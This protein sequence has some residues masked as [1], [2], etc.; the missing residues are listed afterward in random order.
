MA[1]LG[2]L[3][4][5]I[6][7]PK[8][9]KKGGVASTGTHNPSQAQQVLTLPVYREHLDDIFD[10]RQVNDSRQLMQQLFRFDPDVSATV[11]S[12]LTLANTEPLIVA[13]TLDGEID[14]EATAAAWNVIERITRVYDYTL[15]FQLKGSFEILCEQLRYMALLRGAATAELV[16][17]KTLA[18]DNVRIIDG[19]SLKWYEKKP[20]EYKPVQVQS[21]SSTEISLDI[22]TFF[23]SFFRRDPTSIYAYSPFVAAINT[24]AARQ[25]VINDLYR[26]MKITG[27][28]RMDITILEEVLQKAAPADVKADK[29]KLSQWLTDRMNEVRRT[30]ENL[31]ADQ[32]LVHFDSVQATILNEK[33]PSSGIDIDH[34]INVL[35]GQ[36]QAGLKTMS[37]VIGRG[38]SGVN[39]STVE[40]RIAAMNADELNSPIAALLSNLLSFSLHQQGFQGFV[41]VWFE[42]AELRPDT[43]LEPQRLIKTQRLRQDLS[44]GLITDDEYHL[45]V[46]RRLRPESSPELS[47]TGFMTPMPAADPAATDTSQPDPIARTAKPTGSTKGGNANKKGQAKKA[48]PK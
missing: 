5:A 27:F 7:A 11:N 38:E 42:N 44:D 15:G 45:W 20:G 46:Y 23:I 47:G 13:R 25:Q 6:I 35:N 22:P 40:A 39:T 2:D 37:T 29:D 36:N 10:S 31:R 32:A 4:S 30:F 14:R 24:I 8:K 9:V 18:P 19:M 48:V 12:Y 17:D 43:E 33:N 28:P 21:G 41:E 3:L 16:L 1:G 34:V 26:I